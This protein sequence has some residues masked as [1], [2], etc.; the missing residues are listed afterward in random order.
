MARSMSTTPPRDDAPTAGADRGTSDRA[1]NQTDDTLAATDVSG[2]RSGTWTDEDTRISEQV[3][4]TSSPGD[5]S[6][7]AEAAE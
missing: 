5:S 7:K 2:E 4:A 3:L 6:G 1:D